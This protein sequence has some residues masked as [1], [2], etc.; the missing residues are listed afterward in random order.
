MGKKLL[1]LFV[2]LIYAGIATGFSGTNSESEEAESIRY[3]YDE[4]N[5]VIKAEYP[6]G[7][8]ITYYYDKNGNLLETIVEQPEE[9][10][11]STGE[12][13]ATEGTASDAGV[14]GWEIINQA[15]VF[16]NRNENYEIESGVGDLDANGVSDSLL[17]DKAQGMREEGKAE[18]TEE[19]KSY[20]GW[21]LAVILAGVLTTG[22]VW[23]NKRRK[24]DEA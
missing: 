22:I 3:E 8:T 12:A 16:T 17:D 5:R 13:A 9:V 18:S 23:K 24:Q 20:L 19:E 15:Y 1:C 6:D 2:I 10:T 21:I 11:V 7:T 14:P 4:L